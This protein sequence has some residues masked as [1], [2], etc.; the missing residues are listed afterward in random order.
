GTCSERGPDR[1]C[2]GDSGH[3][4]YHDHG[5]QS[6]D[7]RAGGGGAPARDRLSARSRRAAP[8]DPRERQRGRGRLGREQSPM[9]LATIIGLLLAWGALM[10]ALLME[11]GDI[12]ALINLP[13]ALLVFGGTLGA[14][15]ISF[16]MNQ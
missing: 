10:G 4:H 3:G 11:G 5:A 13:A 1:V 6:A 9:D 2:G 12:K 8:S 15:T 7:T 16:K 14:A